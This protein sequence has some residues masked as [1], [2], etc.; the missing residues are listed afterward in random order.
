[1]KRR[2]RG[3]RKRREERE[4]PKPGGE[5]SYGFEW[6]RIQSSEEAVHFGEKGGCIEEKKVRMGVSV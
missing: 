3:E 2:K 5:H 6:H 1:M 4:R